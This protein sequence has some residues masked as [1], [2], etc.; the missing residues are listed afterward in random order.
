MP[1]TEHSA[2]ILAGS[3]PAQSVMS[4]SGYAMD[5]SQAANRLFKELDTQA[6]IKD[7]LGPMEGAFIDSARG[8]AMGRE[9]ALQ[10]RIEAYRHI[11]KKAHWAANE[12]H[13]TKSD[14]VEIVKQA[15]EN[16]K[17][18]RENA[19]KAKA[20]A[21]ANPLAGEPAVAAIESQLQSAI[22]AIV[23]LAKSNAM[24]RDSQGAGTVTALS[25]DISQWAAPFAN[26]VLPQSGGI[27]DMGGLPAAPAPPVPASPGGIKP[28]DYTSTGDN[29]RQAGG[30]DTAQNASNNTQGQPENNVQQTAFKQPDKIEPHE[31]GKPQTSSPPASAPSSP[32]PSSAGSS[33]NPSSVLG[34]MMKP[35]SSGSSSSSPAS[36]SSSS[37]SSSA[38]SPASA[39][40]SSQMA[41]A[42][43]ANAGAGTGAGANAAAN[44][45]GRGPGMASLG[46]GIADTSAKMASGAVNAAS[47]AVSTAT[48]VGSNVAQNVVQAAAQ[49]PA[50]ASPAAAATAPASVGGA[51]VSGGAPMGM[52][53]AAPAGGVGPVNPVTSGGGAPSAPA[54]TPTSPAA[55]PVGGGVPQ[56][57]AAGAAGST[58]APVAVPH[59]S[60][61]GIGADGATGD[62]IFDQAMD[63]GQD[64]I[65]AL[66]AQTLGTGYI[67]IHYAVSLIWERGGTITAWMA[68]S[69]GAS[70]IPLGVRVPH[71]VRLSITDPI[72]GHEL[73]K[74]SSEAGGANPLE[75]VVRQAEAREQ[76]APGSRVLALASSLPM[77]RVMDWA[78]VVG[79]RPVSVN[80]KEV[81]RTT[82]PDMSML[83]RCAVAMPWEWR[84][85]SAFSEEDR[86][87]V[88]ARHMHMAANAGH[89]GGGAAERVIELFEERQPIPE[90]LWADVA[91][92]RFMALIGYQ[93][94]MSNAGQGGAEP[95]ARLL[96]SAR[97]AEVVLCLRDYG[98][99]EGCADLLYASRLAGAPLSPAAA[100]A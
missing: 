37:A 78:G 64:V 86:L 30:T 76:A 70:Y 44:A 77:D 87:R 73:T 50:A 59:S 22:A 16:I 80:P 95:P 62:V 43:G 97:A 51:P 72:I 47:N 31:A 53:P 17:T 2:E 11:S 20:L 96:A 32:S 83:H 28:V 33:S 94:A 7:I 98:S 99:A 42:N 58:L 34:Q 24:A 27:P 8:L 41:N 39:S 40:Q 12:L 52:M 19:E 74:T 46:S 71:D 90:A 91:K 21:R 54:A 38:S 23:A 93:M 67:D 82:G 66:V 15:E 5:Y 4:W 65:K 26:H 9:T 85:A 13:S 6:D 1:A 60:I 69:E 14:L 89:L 57:S 79:A 25:T 81:G 48:N 45:A 18:S 49:A 29:L 75:V 55:G 88:A 35:A 10:N 36:S 61:R 92:Q 84:Q 100:V 63:A 3:W 68:T 56:A